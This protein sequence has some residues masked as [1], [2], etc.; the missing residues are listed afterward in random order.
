MLCFIDDP[1]F[2]SLEVASETRGGHASSHVNTPTH[3]GSDRAKTSLL[4]HE[5]NRTFCSWFRDGSLGDRS[6]E[7]T[8]EQVGR[9]S[10]GGY[11]T[12]TWKA[13][14]PPFVRFSCVRT[15]VSLLS[16]R[17]CS[18]LASA[19]VAPI[20]GSCPLPPC[21]CMRCTDADAHVQCRGWIRGRGAVSSVDR[22]EGGSGL[23]TRLVNGG[24]NHGARQLAQANGR[25]RSGV[26]SQDK[27]LSVTQ[28]HT[29]LLVLLLLIFL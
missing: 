12:T 5:A 17:Y 18:L 19:M 14:R 25:A 20:Y 24:T 21:I 8:A 7:Q 9:I 22:E 6:N 29:S 23:R 2:I 10:S 28:K 16:C 13:R 11:K 3:T 15:R 27:S 26:R 1:P 4:H